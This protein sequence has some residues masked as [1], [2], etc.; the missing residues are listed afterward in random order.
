M[1]DLGE[2]RYFFGIKIARSKEGIV[3]NERKYASELF[4]EV[5]LLSTKPG[6]T[7]MEVNRNLTSATYAEVF[8][9]NKID[10]MLVNAHL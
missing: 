10:T 9:V 7:R 5:G 3:M 2:L 4:D 1:K 6:K 8:D